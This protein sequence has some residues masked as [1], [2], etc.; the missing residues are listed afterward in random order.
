MATTSPMPTPA[1]SVPNRF[2]IRL[3]RPFWIGI[4]AVVIVASAIGVVVGLPAY[5][6]Q[7]AIRE[8]ERV[9]GRIETRPLGPTWLREAIGAKK[10]RAFEGVKLERFPE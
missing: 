4:A 1:P 7:V 9:G 3:P 2:L 6:Q 10:M 8:I 5:R